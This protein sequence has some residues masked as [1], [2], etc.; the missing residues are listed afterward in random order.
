[1]CKMNSAARP[2]TS[3]LHASVQSAKGDREGSK[4]TKGRL[5]ND[6]CY[7][8]SH[9]SHRNKNCSWQKL[10]KLK[11]EGR[12]CKTVFDSSGRKVCEFLTNNIFCPFD[13][14]CNQ[15]H[16]TRG[17]STRRAN[18]ATTDSSDDELER[19]R[20]AKQSSIRAVE[21]SANS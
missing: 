14:K 18:N 3:P 1:M 4:Q 17:S 16:R 21:K 15:S 11:D 6:P 13:K 5:P 2:R 7:L 20:R 19:R 12:A 9:V 8:K 10:R